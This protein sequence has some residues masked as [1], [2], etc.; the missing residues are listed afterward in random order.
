MS[1][2]QVDPA[3][4]CTA[5]PGGQAA[6][7][8]D[9]SHRYV[10]LEGGWGAG[11]TW[12]G[13][14]K[15]LTLHVVNA[16]DGEGRAT[17]VPSA[18]V[19]PT[20]GSAKDYVVPELENAAD[21]CGLRFEYRASGSAAG[22]QFSAPLLLFPDFSTRR[23]PSVVLIRTADSPDTITGW[24]AG[25]AW[26]DEAARWPE[27]VNDPKRDPYTQLAGR[28]RHPGA[29]VLMC[30]FT[31]TNEGDTTRVYREFHSGAPDHALYTVPTAENPVA[32]SWA[33]SVRGSLP[34]ELAAQYFDG[35]AASLRGQKV[36]PV[37]DERVHVS[38][39]LRLA[40]GAPVDVSLDFN[41][42]PGMHAEVGQYDTAADRF[43]VVHE[44][45]APRLDVRGLVQRFVALGLKAPEVR[46]FGDAAGR[47]QWAGTGETCYDIF[48][49][50]LSDAGVPA[51]SLVPLSNPPV[52]DRV[53]AFNI[54]LSDLRGR[55]H[56]AC[57]PSCREL[58]NDLR[59]MRR[60]RDGQ[61]DKADA[62]LSHAADAEGYRVHFL[63]PISSLRVRPGKVGV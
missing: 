7:A 2:L 54:A 6:F 58:V 47:A 55:P 62:R 40:A 19:A 56:W 16:F 26:G 57:H 15:L 50:G 46:V 25:A 31:Y 20:Y 1:V 34:P 28:V 10:A 21:E 63:R 60:D 42:A 61:I 8:V 53:N 24:Q 11:K 41:I 44:I 33:E 5:N 59:E 23:R 51:R 14:R 3:P 48:F 37:F 18:V 13:A 17:F 36:Y 52:V 38:P 39:A 43:V 12:A 32:R 4:A 29:R 27:C 45:Y 9:W 22:G 35:V 30:V 49:E